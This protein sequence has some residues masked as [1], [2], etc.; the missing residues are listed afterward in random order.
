MNQKSVSILRTE[1][2]HSEDEPRGD[3][4][5]KGKEITR[6]WTEKALTGQDIQFLK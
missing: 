2:F 6:Y 4:Y 1:V 3:H 5:L